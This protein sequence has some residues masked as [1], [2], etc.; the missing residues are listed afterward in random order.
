MPFDKSQLKQTTKEI[1]AGACRLAATA[2]QFGQAAAPADGR[3]APVPISILARTT[4]GV[5]RWWWGWVYHD[6]AGFSP[7]KDTL[8]L[9]Y[10]HDDELIVGVA[11]QFV[12]SNDGLTVDGRLVP[13]TAD[14]LAAQI[15][16]RR[17]QGTPYEASISFNP[18][19]I[20]ELG[21]EETAEV[22]GQTVAA[23]AASDRPSISRRV[24]GS[25]AGPNWRARRRCWAC[26]SA[27]KR[28]RPR[29]ARRSCTCSSGES[30]SRSGAWVE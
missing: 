10:L 21:P 5:Y 29:L 20:Q 23:P 3:P 12:A 16:Y 4:N 15:I 17:S 24:T 11:E 22:N 27:T 28:L 7:Q 26:A 18:K 25:G 8:V 1:P 6:M 9:D 30:W 13:F 14:D 19:T 2:V